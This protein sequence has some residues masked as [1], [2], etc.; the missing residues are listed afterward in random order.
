MI[1]SLYGYLPTLWVCL[2]TSVVADGLFRGS[3]GTRLQIDHQLK[4]RPPHH[5]VIGNVVRY[6][7]MLDSRSKLCPGKGNVPEKEIE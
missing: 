4:K 2:R 5:P 7:S 1:P 3:L 6:L